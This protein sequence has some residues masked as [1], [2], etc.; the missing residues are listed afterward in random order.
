MS[1]C[2]DLQWKGD[3]SIGVPTYR[4]EVSETTS[5]KFKCKPLIIINKRTYKPRAQKQISQIIRKAPEKPKSECRCNKV[6]IFA[7]VVMVLFILQSR[8]RK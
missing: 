1:N 4:K 5:G 2:R 7:F 6:I 8:F 3:G